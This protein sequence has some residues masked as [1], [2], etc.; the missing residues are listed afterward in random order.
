ML[1]RLPCTAART[2]VHTTELTFGIGEQGQHVDEAN[3]LSIYGK[4]GN[5]KS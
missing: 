3:G 5:R 1:R 2:P 4:D